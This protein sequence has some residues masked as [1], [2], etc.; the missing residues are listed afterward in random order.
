MIWNHIIYAVLLLVLKP[1]TIKW[2]IIKTVLTTILVVMEEFMSRNL[3]DYAEAQ[4]LKKVIHPLDIRE[5]SVPCVTE[6][7]TRTINYC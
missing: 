4:E 2:L 7:V 1:I 3:V 5:G 6:E